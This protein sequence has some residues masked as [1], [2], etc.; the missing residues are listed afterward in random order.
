MKDFLNV[1]D[2]LKCLNNEDLLTTGTH[3]FSMKVFLSQQEKLALGFTS[4]GD[5][6][7]TV[8]PVMKARE[9]SCWYSLRPI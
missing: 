9:E 7:T 8:V 6:V 3:Y 4:E 5:Y 2:Y 1:K